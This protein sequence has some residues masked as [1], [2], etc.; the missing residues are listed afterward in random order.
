MG[1]V[2]SQ[3]YSW[4]LPTNYYSFWGK[5]L[6]LHYLPPANGLHLID[7]TPTVFHAEEIKV[8]NTNE[9]IF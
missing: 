1:S 2:D 6:D 3:I 7:D 4:E 5:L 8:I 9:F